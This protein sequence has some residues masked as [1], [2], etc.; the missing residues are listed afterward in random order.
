M[1]LHR[2]TRSDWSELSPQER[3]LWQRLAVASSGVVTPANIVTIIGA[4][5]VLYGLLLL[6]RNHLTVGII[7]VL[8]GRLADILDGMVAEAT[9]TKSPLGEALDATIDKILI[10][11]SLWVLLDR[12]LLPAVVIWV[13]L[14][15]AVY[16]IAVS[17]ISRQLKTY[18]HPS[19]SGKLGAVFQWACVGAY[20]LV[21]ILKQHS[22]SSTV[23]LYVG[24]LCFILFV[25]LAVWSSYTYTKYV[26]YRNEVKS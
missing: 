10:I 5:L 24:R 7:L 11:L 12:H 19:L 6:Y 18:L 14:V 4:G 13:M 15:H 2:A 21:D 20:L 23:P 26:Y 16:V 25:V 8:L 22:T 17:Y 3:N 1:N 9:K